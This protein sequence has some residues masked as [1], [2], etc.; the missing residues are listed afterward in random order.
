MPTIGT[1]ATISP[2]IE[3]VSSR[4]AEVSSHHGP[5]IS[6]TANPIS[7][8][9]CARTARTASAQPTRATNG[10]RASA[11]PAQRTKTTTGT[12]TLCTATLM[13]R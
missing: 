10:S 11:A 3:L 5:T 12:D 8:G 7:H 6:R 1:A 9:Q 4:S 2:A 13:N